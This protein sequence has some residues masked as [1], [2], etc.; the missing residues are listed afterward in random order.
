MAAQDSK[1]RVALLTVVTE[2]GVKRWASSFNSAR[3]DHF[4]KEPH[5]GKVPFLP[6]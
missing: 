5:A 1:R 4:N 3:I 6:H 2:H